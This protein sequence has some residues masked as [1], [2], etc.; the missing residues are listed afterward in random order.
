MFLALVTLVPGMVLPIS[1]GWE[2]TSE[3][4][5]LS[6]V[7]TIRQ[8]VIRLFTSSLSFNCGNHVSWALLI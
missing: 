3:M 7:F 2:V 6:W 8:P 1:Q 5:N 4:V